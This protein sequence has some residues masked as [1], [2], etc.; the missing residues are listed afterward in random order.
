MVPGP[1]QPLKELSTT[2]LPGFKSGRCVGQTTLPP[3]ISRISENVGAS[4]SHN[5]K[6]LLHG[7]YRVA[8]PY[9]F[10]G[11]DVLW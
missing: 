1:T 11:F 10:V 7:L 8:L 4:T 9:C 5:P 2:N 3:S 6:G